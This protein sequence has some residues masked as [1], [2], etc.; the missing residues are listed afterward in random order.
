MEELVLP[1]PFLVFLVTPLA[2]L[3][4]HGFFDF[5]LGKVER[6]GLNFGPLI[7]GI[8]AHFVNSFRK[9]EILVTR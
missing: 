1:T 4:K 8:S 5:K 9:W 3:E 7:E 6:R 2:R